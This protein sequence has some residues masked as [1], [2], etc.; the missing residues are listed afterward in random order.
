MA[1]RGGVSDREGLSLHPG[2]RVRVPVLTADHLGITT[3]NDPV[4]HE[5]GHQRDD[6]RDDQAGDQ[7][8][9]RAG[10]QADDRVEDRVEVEVTVMHR[11]IR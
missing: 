4:S 11:L 5:A 6:Q 10:D 7:V 1:D 2:L 8:E 9:D 3:A